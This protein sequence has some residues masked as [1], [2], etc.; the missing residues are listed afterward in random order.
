[1]ANQRPI[2]QRDWLRDSRQS[3]A[4]IWLH[5]DTQEYSYGPGYS[6]TFT[7]RDCTRSVDISLD[8]S[9]DDDIEALTLIRDYADKAIRWIERRRRAMREEGGDRE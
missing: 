4:G 7:L 2:E 5:L 9:N 6:G 1:M 8:E 3:E